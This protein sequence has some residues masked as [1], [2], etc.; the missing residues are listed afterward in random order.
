MCPDCLQRNV[1]TERIDTLINRR[2]RYDSIA[3]YLALFPM[4]L[5]YLTVFTAPVALFIA[6]RYWKAPGSIVSRIRWRMPL[7][8]TVSAL[9]ISGWLILLITVVAAIRGSL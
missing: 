4:L 9:Q 2:T 5:F 7:A 6:I 1:S 3:L 8:A